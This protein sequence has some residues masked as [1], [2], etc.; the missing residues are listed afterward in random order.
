MFRLCFVLVSLFA[1]QSAIYAQDPDIRQLMTEE[2]FA[3]SGLS[4]LSNEEIGAINRWLIRYTVQDAE[5]MLESN[6]AVQEADYEDITSRIDGAFSGWN[7]PTQFRLKNGQIWE[8]NS[9]RTYSYSATDPEVR[10][11]RNWMG[12]YRMRIVETGQAI[13][14]RRVQ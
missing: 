9:T 6:P 7:G 5:E 2:E 13:N 10:I 1:M 14:V 3:A 11:S 4:R 12:I 8:T